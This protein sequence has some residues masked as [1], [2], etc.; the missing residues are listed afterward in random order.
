M[1]SIVERFP[2][3]W[4]TDVTVVRSGGSDPKGNPL[5]ATEHE[6]GPCLVSTDASTEDVSSRSDAPETTAYLFT[7]PGVKV[8]STDRLRIP[9][10]LWPSGD[11]QVS[12]EPSPTPLGVRVPL[13]R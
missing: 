8:L 11:F 3:E 5:P 4:L 2:P 1:T 7:P 9:P 13:Q 10:G 6:I 12:G